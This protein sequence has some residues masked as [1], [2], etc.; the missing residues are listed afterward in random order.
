MIPGKFAYVRPASVAD[1]VAA[2]KDDCEDVFVL[3]GGQT[4]V[5]M[6][7]M[8]QAQP[9]RLL[10]LNGIE[11]LRAIEVGSDAIT[12]GA[13]VTQ[14]AV[15]AHKDLASACPLLGAAAGQIADPQVRNRGTVGGNAVNGDPANDMPAIMQ[16][17]DAE[18]VLASASGE[19]SVKARDFYEGAL[20][21]QRKDEEILVRIK[22]PSLPAGHGWAY[23]KQK[24]KIGDYATSAVGVVLAKKGDALEN[25]AIGLTNVG[26]TPILATDA[27][28]ALKSV[29]DVDAAA[30]KAAE[31]ADPME[32]D[33]R[34]PAAFR[35]QLTGVLAKEA[36]TA[37]IERAK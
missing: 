16:I 12:L 35:K 15:L 24:R 34:G 29:G 7:K 36:I 2:L 3:A 1:A 11:E 19:R 4:L 9:K 23:V 31:Q 26:E 32:P 13:M 6:M 8:R 27:A 33:P 18:Y 5:S 10:D 25:V 37:A 30:A 20:T 28:A 22:I 21:T 14:S 17:L